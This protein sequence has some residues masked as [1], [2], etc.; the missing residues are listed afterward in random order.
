VSIKNKFGLIV[1]IAAIGLIVLSAFWLDSERARIFSEQK[2]QTAHAVEL[3]FSVIVHYHQMEVS[4]RLSRE[5]A[6]RI[7]LAVIRDMRYNGDN[8]LWINDL[9][10]KMIMHPMRLDLE[11][12][13]LTDSFL[14]E[15]LDVVKH[16]GA[17][18]VAYSWIRPG[19]KAN[20]LVPKISFV[21]GFLPWRWMIGTGIYIEDVDAAWRLSAI[22]AISITMVIVGLLFA[23]SMTT[24]HS[25]FRPLG[26]VVDRM[27]RVAM[28]QGDLTGLPDLELSGGSGGRSGHGKGSH[29][30]EV[31]V[32]GF[33][34]MLHYIQRRDH[35][36]SQHRDSL[37]CQ[38]AL[39]TAELSAANSSLEGAYGDIELFLE[40]IP[41]ILIGLDSQGQIERWN[42]AAAR[43]FGIRAEDAIGCALS[44]CGIAWVLPDMGARIAEW[45]A[46][47]KLRHCDDLAYERNG[48]T[49][50]LG[51]SVHPIQ[52]DQRQT[53]GFL[54]T[55][56]DV[57]ERKFLEGQLRQA[58]KLEAIG[59]LAAGVAHEINTPT[60][61][62]TDNTRFMKDAWT[63]VQSLIGLCRSIQ[64]EASSSGSVSP[65]S[66][67]Q[68]D[69][70]STECDLDYLQVEVPSA[71]DQSLDG[72]ARVAAIVRAMK[73]F[74]HPG[75]NEK[76][77]TDINK[78]IGSTIVLAS[79]EW[80]NVADVTTD[81]ADLPLVPCFAGEFNE[82]IL[83]LLVNAAHAIGDVVG[84]TGVKGQIR[85][86]TACKGNWVVVS[87]RDSGSGIPAAIRSRI[88]EPFFTTKAPGKGTGQGLALAHSLIVKKHRGQIWF[89]TELGQGTT[90]YVRIPL[91]PEAS[92]ESGEPLPVHE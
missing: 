34:E 19:A 83:N 82:T 53:A 37:E 68:F 77:P 22:H 48:A 29:E 52:R 54:I 88:F 41:S 31:L 86:A 6:Q 51:V 78:A 64:A 72:L 12:K 27:K 59:Q 92:S 7:S 18:F 62:V 75:E 73:E 80:K 23:I 14:Y 40:T 55:G 76:Q 24:F 46:G 36:L 44:G 2:R 33:N 67:V 17:G 3:A 56:A 60:Q 74:A 28:C 81:F 25:I 16:S 35:D 65:R 5:E 49:R 66:L 85:V 20:G 38:V 39:R 61:Y 13:V 21:R 87:I 30:I 84:N 90:F 47:G 58:Q 26:E 42:G 50:F 45:M 79:S 71:I 15:M 43:T 91:N 1:M 9:Q 57:T 63:S 4:H 70:V 8:Y 89:E 10:R 69:R 11:G 32:T